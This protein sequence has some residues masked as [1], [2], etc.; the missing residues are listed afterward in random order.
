MNIV[1]QGTE[2]MSDEELDAQMAMIIRAQSEFGA[3]A[4]RRA[5]DAQFP[6]V[7]ESRLK[8]ST[9]RLAQRGFAVSDA[10]FRAYKK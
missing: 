8:A 6:D 2:G 5:I 10:E 3:T 9:A 4:V 7:E 1:W